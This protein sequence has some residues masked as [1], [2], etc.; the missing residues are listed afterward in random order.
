MGKIVQFP[1]TDMIEKLEELL[2]QARRHEIRAMAVIVV[3]KG[4]TD[5]DY[6]PRDL[7]KLRE[8]HHSILAGAADIQFR[9]QADM[10]GVVTDGDNAPL[11]A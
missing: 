4:E 8:H 3:R 10:Y 2:D 6:L 1:K 11:S 9:L 5:T 7:K